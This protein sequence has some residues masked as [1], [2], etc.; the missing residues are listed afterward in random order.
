MG[1]PAASAK[2]IRSKPNATPT[3]WSIRPIDFS[4][5]NVG[6][7]RL[8]PTPS[9]FHS[10]R[11]LDNV[12]LDIAAAE[13]NG[14]RQARDAAANDQNLPDVAGHAIPASASPP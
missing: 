7:V 9:T 14:E 8:M 1:R 13:R 3:H 6:P 4:A 5:R 11:K 12:D 10:R 2:T